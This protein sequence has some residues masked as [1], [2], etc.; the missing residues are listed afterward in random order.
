M[1]PLRWLLCLFY[2]CPYGVWHDWRPIQIRGRYMCVRCG[3]VSEP[4]HWHWESR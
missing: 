1:H 2:K 3:K 4:Q